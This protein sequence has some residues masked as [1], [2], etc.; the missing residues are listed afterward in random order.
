LTPYEEY[1]RK[2]IDDKNS[3]IAYIRQKMANSNSI[4]KSVLK[5]RLIKLQKGV[6]EL[7]EAL[8][9]YLQGLEWIREPNEVRVKKSAELFQG[10]P[11]PKP[12]G[13]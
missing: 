3:Q 6:S 12:E 13:S 5:H 1:L 2:S 7:N 8:R 9:E 11:Q 10:E 4:E